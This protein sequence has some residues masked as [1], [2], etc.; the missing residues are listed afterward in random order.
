MMSAATLRAAQMMR[1]TRP[2]KASRLLILPK[3]KTALTAT[4]LLLK[5]ACRTTAAGDVEP[6][7]VHPSQQE[8]FVP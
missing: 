8:L 3:E 2:Q 1:S 6:P 5:P 7:A 4:V